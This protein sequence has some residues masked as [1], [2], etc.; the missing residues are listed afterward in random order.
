MYT[1]LINEEIQDERRK[2]KVFSEDSIYLAT[3]KIGKNNP[4]ENVIRKN[5]EAVNKWN[6]YATLA[7]KDMS[8]EHVKEVKKQ[9]ILQP[10]K[11]SAAEG[12]GPEMYR[13]IVVIATKTLNRL[14]KEWFNLHIDDRP[15]ARDELF[16]KMIKYCKE[17]VIKT[18]EKCR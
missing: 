9:V 2:L 4:M 18:K 3:K 8:E 16:G 11:E 5:N 1:E 12:N 10:I 7:A 17:K 15:G 14:I 13:E 6:F